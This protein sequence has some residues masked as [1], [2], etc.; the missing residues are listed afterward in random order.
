MPSA[1]PLNSGS[2]SDFPE[3]QSESKSAPPAVEITGLEQLKFSADSHAWFPSF[4][5]GHCGEFAGNLG[6]LF[7]DFVPSFRSYELAQIWQRIARVRK[8]DDSSFGLS[9]CDGRSGV[10]LR[11]WNFGG[12]AFLSGKQGGPKMHNRVMHTGTVRC[13]ST[14]DGF[15]TTS[16]RTSILP[17]V[18]SCA[19]DKPSTVLIVDDERGVA[20]VLSRILCFRGFRTRVA[21]NGTDAIRLARDVEPEVIL[22]DLSMQGVS[23]AEVW[24]ALQ[25]DPSTARI[26]FILMSGDCVGE[27]QGCAP[28]LILQKPFTFDELTWAM[29]AVLRGNAAILNA[30]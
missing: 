4:S 1:K 18:F 30:A 26:P 19:P 3:N 2:I 10:K 14:S 29:S 6:P 21:L 5:F 24:D 16:R 7:G 17:G 9:D 20:E 28:D 12:A 13:L 27:A 15:A 22:C 23:G 11:R 8:S 25:Q